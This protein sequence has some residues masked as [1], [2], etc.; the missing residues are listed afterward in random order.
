MKPKTPRALAE[1][2]VILVVVGLIIT[3]P[4]AGFSLLVLAGV[5]TAF[6]LAFGSKIMRLVALLLLLIILALAIWKFPDARLHLQRYRE[7]APKQPAIAP[8]GQSEQQKKRG[9][10]H[11]SWE[12]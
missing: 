7:H 8:H 12:I 1:F 11:D 4:L 2:A 6:A 10:P 5:F 3:D 9:L